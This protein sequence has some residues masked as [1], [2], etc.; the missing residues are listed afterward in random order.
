MQLTI[1]EIVAGAILAILTTI[2]VESLRKPRLRLSIAP[3]TV[4]DYEGRPA[5]SA[6]FLSLDLAN[7]PLPRMAR[8]MLRE[9]ALQCHGTVTFHHLDGQNIFGRSMPLR[10]SASPEPVMPLVVGN[11][12]VLIVSPS[13]FTLE[14]RIDVYPDESQSLAIAGRFDNEIE[15]YGWSNESYVSTPPWRNPRWLLPKGRYLVK[16]TVVS[17]GQSCTG[18]YRLI[19]DVP[20]QDFRLEYAMRGDHI[21]E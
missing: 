1:I 9:A 16:V 4:L 21:H 12:Q 11:K 15:C 17:S 18:T 5:S 8:W 2:A 7:Q 13:V 3:P 10:W 6:T 20:Q 14:P 19:N